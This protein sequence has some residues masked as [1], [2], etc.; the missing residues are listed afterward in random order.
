VQ[1][2]ADASL[3]VDGAVTADKLA[4]NS[5]VAGKVAAGAISTDQLA[6]NAV[7]AGKLA[8]D[9]ALITTAAQMGTAVVGTA[10][11]QDLAVGT[12]KITGG[13]VSEAV[14]ASWSG[15]VETYSDT[16]FLNVPTFT[17]TIPGKYILRASLIF[18]A[19]ARMKVF[20]NGSIAYSADGWG[21]K[22]FEFI[23]DWGVGTY[24][25]SIWGNSESAGSRARYAFGSIV[26][27]KR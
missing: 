13:A 6:A 21:E 25:V 14:H 9:E 11:I 24:T 7:R 20:V 17:V 10:T 22:N 3:I 8:V 18:T 1:V 19:G 12:L 16:N 4:A 23:G 26:L 27:L 15:D 2:A 5:V